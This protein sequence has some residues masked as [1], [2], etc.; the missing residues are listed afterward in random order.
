[1]TISKA[2]VCIPVYDTWKINKWEWACCDSI[3]DG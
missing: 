3:H 1:M 2:M